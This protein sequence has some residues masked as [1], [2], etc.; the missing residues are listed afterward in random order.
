MPEF[1][2]FAVAA[3]MCVL[4]FGVGFIAALS[5]RIAERAAPHTGMS[6]E[7]ESLALPQT[8]VR[9]PTLAE[10]PAVPSPT[11]PQPAISLPRAERAHE[12]AAHALTPSTAPLPPQHATHAVRGEGF[13]P[14]TSP[15]E[16]VFLFGDPHVEPVVVP[17]TAPVYRAPE[18]NPWATR[19]HVSPTR[20]AP[21]DIDLL[22]HR[23]QYA[24]SA[25]R[26]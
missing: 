19:Q 7:P 12:Q 14:R 13:P 10:T 9:Q 2:V 11:A 21:A 20:L 8:D 15:P 18:P 25:R 17:A 6:D 1:V 23:S 16:K 24:R 26:R 5:L 3:S 4:C 22:P